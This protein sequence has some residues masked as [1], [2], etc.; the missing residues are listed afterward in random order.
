VCHIKLWE[1][2]RQV[3]DFDKVI[4]IAESEL[5]CTIASIKNKNSTRYDD[6]SNKILRLC[7]KFLSKPPT[8]IFNLSLK[9]GIFPYCLKYSIISPLFKKG[10]RSHLTNYCPISLLTSFYK[11]F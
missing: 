5:I 2:T 1:N 9:H 4:P 10:D 11:I 3:T 8:Y 7:G 6:A